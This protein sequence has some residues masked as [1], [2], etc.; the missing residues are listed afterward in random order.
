MQM[1]LFAAAVSAV[2]A[3]GCEERAGGRH[4]AFYV[5]KPLTTLLILGAVLTAPGADPD[6]RLWVAAALLLSTCGDTALMR[7]GD[8]WFL[9]GLSSFLLAHGVFVAAFLADGNHLPPLWTT[10]PVLAGVGFLIW[11]LPRTG[12]LWLPVTLYAAALI[13]M[14]VTAAARMELRG[15]TGAMLAAAG[16]LVF[17]VSDAALAVRRFHGPYPR[18]QALILSTYWSALGL[19]AASVAASGALAPA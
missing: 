15:D 10:V 18:A 16:A 1:F 11:L 14:S 9:A 7:E 12:P 6:Y 4:P 5:L 19:I 17:L 13:G 3:V 8:A 2:L